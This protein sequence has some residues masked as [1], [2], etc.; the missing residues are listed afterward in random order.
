MAF[1]L[2]LPDIFLANMG[3]PLMWMTILHLFIGNAVIALFEG[4]LL[5][6]CFKVRRLSAFGFALLANYSSAWL[7]AWIFPNHFPGSADVNITNLHTWL[8]WGVILSF[9]VTLVVEAPFIWLTLRKRPHP[10]RSTVTGTLMVNAVSYPL[11]AFLFWSSSSTSMLTQLEITAPNAMDAPKDLRLYF[12][13]P[14][15]D[16][17]LQSDLAGANPVTVKALP[18]LPA[19]WR[20]HLCALP[21]TPRTFDLMLMT[22]PYPSHEN[23]WQLQVLQA[24]FSSDAG[25]EYGVAHDMSPSDTYPNRG[26]ASRM[27]PS[28]GAEDSYYVGTYPYEGIKKLGA[29]RFHFALE[30]PFAMW[31][32]SHATQISDELVV[33]Q[34]GKD[35]ICLL[36]PYSRKITLLTRGRSPVVAR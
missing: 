7:G 29:R 17:V 28:A 3:T 14:E 8:W 34:L 31:Q 35:Q 26:P 12:L 36:R 27:A 20:R 4:L 2:L 6:Q 32:V 15:G 11:L 9:T 30:T 1:P 24:D 33:F 23:E 10:I 21:T 19:E 18:A 25:V 5:A 13:S 16:Q 22:G